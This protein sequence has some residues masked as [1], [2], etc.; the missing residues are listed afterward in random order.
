VKAMDQD[1]DLHQVMGP[2]VEMLVEAETR[3]LR[4]GL[5]SE[6]RKGRVVDQKGGVGN[7]IQV[8]TKSTSRFGNTATSG[9][10]ITSEYQ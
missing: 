9:R 1:R 3:H 6:N 7:R 8:F 5:L 10:V 2:N 4:E